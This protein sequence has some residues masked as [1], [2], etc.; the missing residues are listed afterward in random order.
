VTRRVAWREAT[1]AFQALP[2][3]ILAGLGNASLHVASQLETTSR[4]Q[5]RTSQ[6]EYS[7]SSLEASSQ[8]LPAVACRGR[9]VG[10]QLGA[11][12]EGGCLL[13]VEQAHCRFSLGVTADGQ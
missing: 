10:V 1:Q 8:S 9:L 4:T 11:D 5:N 2:D 6:G 12:A 13:V 3:A 7:S